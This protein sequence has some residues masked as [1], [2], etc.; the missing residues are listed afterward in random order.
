M[1]GP[2]ECMSLVSCIVTSLGVT[3]GPNMPYIANPWTLIDE[4][5]LTQGHILKKG[6]DDSLVFF[7]PGY[8][9]KIRLPNPDFRLDGQGPLIVPL[10][11]PRC[12]S[13]SGDR[14]T[15]TASKRASRAQQPPPQPSPQPSPQPQ[16]QPTTSPYGTWTSTEYMPGV[17][18]GYAPGWDQHMYQ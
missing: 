6:S 10:K 5:Y 15:R 12:S 3:Q 4:A 8:A 11:E 7:Y 2:I 14:V 9:S 17:T 16:P 1:A 18:L 13:V